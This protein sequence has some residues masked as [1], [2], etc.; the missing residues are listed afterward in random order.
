MMPVPRE[1]LKGIVQRLKTVNNVLGLKAQMWSM[2]FMKLNFA[3][4]VKAII[5]RITKHW[6]KSPWSAFTLNN[7]SRI[8]LGCF[9]LGACFTASLAEIKHATDCPVEFRNLNKTRKGLGYILHLIWII[10]H[11]TTSQFVKI[12][13][14]FKFKPFSIRVYLTYCLLCIVF[15]FFCYNRQMP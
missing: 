10:F 7:Y 2:K 1:Y 9:I 4:L 3:G 11:T 15:C 12:V 6:A 8:S 14:S 5:P 13:I